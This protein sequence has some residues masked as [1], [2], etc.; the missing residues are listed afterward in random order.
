MSLIKRYTKSIC[1]LL[2]VTLLAN[3][4]EAANNEVDCRTI[5]RN[6]TITAFQEYESGELTYAEY[7]YFVS[8]VCPGGYG[9]CLDDQIGDML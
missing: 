3:W 8:N 9:A 5:L 4:A 7:I 1:L 2:L 6:C